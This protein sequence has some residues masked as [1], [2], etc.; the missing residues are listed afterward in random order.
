MRNYNVILSN[1][2]SNTLFKKF[3]NLKDP[4]PLEA[5]TNVVYQLCCENCNNVYIGE[6]KKKVC[7]RVNQHVAAVRN[8]NELSLV[9]KHCNE[10][11]HSINFNNPQILIQNSN[12]RARRFL[13]SFFTDNN[14]NAFNRSMQF[15]EIYAPIVNKLIRKIN[16]PN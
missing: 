4:L 16:L 2:P 15:S 9:F 13:E 1:K 8:K 11:N 3:N 5:K 7:E 12:V 14:P 6:T 10:N